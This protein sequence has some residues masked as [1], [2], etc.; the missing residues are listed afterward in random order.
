MMSTFLYLIL[1]CQHINALLSMQI[2]V[3]TV[4][5]TTRIYNE[6]HFR[7]DQ[8]HQIPSNQPDQLIQHYLHKKLWNAV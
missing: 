2:V 6:V 7:T 3:F 5:S 1:K 8:S 4:T